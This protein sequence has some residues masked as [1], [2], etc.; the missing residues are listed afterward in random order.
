MAPEEDMDLPQTQSQSHTQ[1][2]V[3]SQDAD[4]GRDVWGRLIAK[5]KSFT[6]FGMYPL[7]FIPPIIDTISALCVNIDF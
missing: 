2:Q 3:F 6:S 4:E 1:D 5:H 7:S